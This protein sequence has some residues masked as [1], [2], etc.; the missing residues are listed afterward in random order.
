MKGES[1]FALLAGAAI[2]A[3]LGVLFAPDKGEETRRKVKEA[4]EDGYAKA[5]ETAGDLYGQAKDKAEEV[6]GKVKDNTSN[7]RDELNSLRDILAET[8]NELKEDA[9][10]KALEQLQKLEQALAKSENQS[11]DSN[12]DDQQSETV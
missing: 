9:R 5:K 8:G 7:V 11:E 6:Y 12:I 4:A 2:G 3:A 10:A 1:I